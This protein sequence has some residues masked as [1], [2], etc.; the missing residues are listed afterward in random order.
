MLQTFL[1][2]AVSNLFMTFAWYGHLKF[3][4]GRPLVLAIA[5]SWGIA[6][7]E[8]CFQVPANRIG[9]NTLSLVQLK[10]SQEIITMVVFT[11]F[12]VVYMGV[13][14]SKNLA[15][16]ALCLVGSAYFIFKDGL[17]VK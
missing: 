14:V 7:L 15:W 5:V 10:V 12:A 4:N 11:I 1:L 9:F 13:P 3:M 17:P 16:A 8:Y 2:L 6:L